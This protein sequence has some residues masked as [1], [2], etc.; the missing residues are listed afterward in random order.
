[1]WAEF[2]LTSLIVV[3]LP[4]TGVIYTIGIGL[5]R[6]PLA[7]IAA[8]AGCTTGILPHMAAAI[9]GVA[10]LL[11][12]SALIFNAFKIAGLVYLL[13]LAWSILQAQGPLQIAA[14]PEQKPLGRVALTGFLINILNPKLSIFFLAFLPQF[15]TSG[16][17]GALMLM[18]ALSAIFMG[19]TF[20]VF[21]GYGVFAARIRSHVTSRPNVMA[22]IR[23]GF[24]A[25]FAAFGARLMFEAA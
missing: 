5:T 22:W 25:A 8:A 16:E 4:G 24:A 14:Q 19:I 12:T 3:L 17:T 18:I 21:V 15:V 10:A 1:M 6:G 2:L 20:V 9:F 11:H 7:S 13:Y 23:R